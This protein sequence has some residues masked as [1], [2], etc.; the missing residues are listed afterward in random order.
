MYL[1]GLGVVL[2]P[3]WIMFLIGKL[4][5][6]AIVVLMVSIIYLPVA[7]GLYWVLKQ[8]I[9]RSRKAVKIVVIIALASPIFYLSSVGLYHAPGA[10]WCELT[11]GTVHEGS[12]CKEIKSSWIRW[13]YLP[14]FTQNTKAGTP[15]QDE[16]IRQSLS[17]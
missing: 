6:L 9:D 3:M 5:A 1:F 10:A 13:M 15:A 14:E 8:W 17:D 7:Y 16:A 2:L 11:G 4:F 12:S